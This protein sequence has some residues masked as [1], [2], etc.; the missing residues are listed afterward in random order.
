MTS[1]KEEIF[2]PV[3]SVIKS[4]SIEQS[5]ALANNNDLWLSAVIFGDNISQCKSVAK[6]LEWGMIF[7]N[8]A[9]KS[10]AFLP[11][12]WVKKSWYGKENGPDGLKAFTNKKVVLY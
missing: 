10:Q 12:W 4:T 2:W 7:V 5:I 6:Q 11:F 1:F 3:A 8:Q 9:A